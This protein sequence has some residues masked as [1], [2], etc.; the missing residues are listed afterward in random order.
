MNAGIDGSGGLHSVRALGM[1]LFAVLLT[2]L[3]QLGSSVAP[4]S[5]GLTLLG[6]GFVSINRVFKNLP[7]NR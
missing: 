1:V 2:A 3:W 5:A 4:E 6:L 7:A